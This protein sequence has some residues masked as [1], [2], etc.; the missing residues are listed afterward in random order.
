MHTTIVRAIASAF[1]LF[2]FNGAT[3]I[4]AQG[5]SVGGK[6]GVN[7]ATTGG[8]LGG[9]DAGIRKPAFGGFITVVPARPFGLQAELLYSPKGSEA[10]G[11]QVLDGGQVFRT[12]TF[13]ST[14]AYLELPIL[15]RLQ[16]PMTP[17]NRVGLHAVFGPSVALQLGCTT[18]VRFTDVSNTTGQ[19]ISEEN[20]ELDCS[21]S[22]KNTDFSLVFGG[23]VDFA[24]ADMGRLVLEAR[25]TLGLTTFSTTPDFDAKNRVFAVLIGFGYRIKR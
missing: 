6:F 1:A 17:A 18:T 16:A 13:S 21:E 10:S 22:L 15:A 9:G 4:H 24:V 8:A 14:N 25:Y 19:I 2:L 11:F 7:F 23:G 3:L 20:L 5:I 12:I